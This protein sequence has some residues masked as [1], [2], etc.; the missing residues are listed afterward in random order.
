MRK[1]Q[2][3][4]VKDNL[5]ERDKKYMLEITSVANVLGKPDV[6]VNEMAQSAKALATNHDDMSSMPWHGG[7]E[8]KLQQTVN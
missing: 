1:R 4:H 2:E 6:G 8:E 3:I 5:W 7:Q